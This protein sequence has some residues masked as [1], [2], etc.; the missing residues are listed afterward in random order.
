MFGISGGEFITLAFVALILIGPNKLPEFAVQSAKLIRKVRNFAQSMV[1]ELK[2][3][4]G[5]E[6]SDLEVTDLHPKKFIKR[7]IDT[8]LIE[9]NELKNEINGEIKK[10]EK[11][12]KIDPDLL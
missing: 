7:H 9:T 10:I 12:A 4:L 2:E 3:N 5:P 6:Y 11:N 8:A 1:N